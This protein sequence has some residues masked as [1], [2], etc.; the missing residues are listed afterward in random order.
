MRSEQEMYA[1]I[2]DTAR[3][4]DRIRA[5]WLNGSRANPDA[6]RDCLQDFDIVYAVTEVEPFRDAAWIERFGEIAV[7]QQPDANDVYLFPD[8][9]DASG[10]RQVWLMQFADGNRIDLTVLRLDRALA[11]Y[12]T[13]S[14]TKP[15]LDKDGILPPLPPAD[16]RD[17]RT[18]LPERGAFDAI[19]NEFWWTAPYVARALW[20]A[21][22]QPGSV[23]YA[24]DVLQSC[25][26]QELIRMLGFVACTLQGAPVNIGK[27]GKNLERLLPADD[28]NRLL[29]TFP[30][31]E[32]NAVW[33][34]LFAA[35][36][37]FSQAA[38]TVAAHCGFVYDER[39]EAGS[40][41]FLD[42][43]RACPGESL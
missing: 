39:Q 28:W 40:R 43:C 37:L 21:A 4:D 42:R 15:L 27:G 16:D 35:A 23:L 18:R 8:E 17:Y 24:L 14:L 5:V 12:G 29:R 2:L 11:Q 26:R 3:A 33:D 10:T 36:D 30:A 25:V 6:H 19:C 34:A 32:P 38:K 13:D 9:M 7:V 41:A 22:G 20:R 1:Q 31:A